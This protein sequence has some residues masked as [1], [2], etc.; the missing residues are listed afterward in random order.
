M[1]GWSWSERVF[2]HPE[3]TC[4][5]C[6]VISGWRGK[7][8]ELFL[9][10]NRLPHRWNYSPARYYVRLS[11]SYPWLTD[12]HRNTLTDTHFLVSPTAPHSEST[13]ASRR[14]IFLVFLSWCSLGF[15]C[16]SSTH[17]GYVCAPLQSSLLWHHV[18]VQIHLTRVF[19]EAADG[20]EYSVGSNFNTN[21]VD[22]HNTYDIT[23]E[24]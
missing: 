18:K 13:W 20:T 15:Q 4:G 8:G 24:I 10:L 9:L 14:I 19:P 23:N 12:R 7:G 11:L 21:T 17:L 16:T 22:M 5:S 3:D 6:I 2:L 1:T